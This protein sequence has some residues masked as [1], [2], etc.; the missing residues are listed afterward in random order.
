MIISASRLSLGLFKRSE[1]GMKAYVPYVGD[2]V[3]VT[4]NFEGIKQ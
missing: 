3:H 1:F 4:I 2:D